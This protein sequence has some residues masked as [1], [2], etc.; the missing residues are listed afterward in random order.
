[1]AALRPRCGSRSRRAIMRYVVAAANA[2]DACPDG[3]ERWLLGSALAVVA[4]GVY[5]TGRLRRTTTF[6]QS[7]AAS[8]HASELANTARCPRRCAAVVP[9]SDAAPANPTTPARRAVLTLSADPEKV[10]R[11]APDVASLVALRF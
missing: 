10:W 2:T 7:V 9:S 4:S 6:I 3:N 5:S 1:M 11:P 8:V